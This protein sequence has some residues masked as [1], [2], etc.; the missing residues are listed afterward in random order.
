MR[1][2]WIADLGA[3]A[4]E[5]AP[6]EARHL[7]DVLRARLGD[8]VRLFD[9]EGREREARVA[10]VDRRG[11]RLSAAGPVL[12]APPPGPPDVALVL[13][14]LRGEAMDRVVRGATELGVR[15]ILPLVAARSVRGAKDGRGAARWRRIAREAARQSGRAHLPIVR[16]PAPLD[17]LVGALPA[18]RRIVLWEAERALALAPSGSA[19][20]LAVG[21]EGGWEADE[22]ERLR[23]SGFETR[24]L[25]DATLRAETAALA[26]VAIVRTHSLKGGAGAA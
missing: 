18:G 9:G 20:V 13:A 25:S 12:R 23:A 5:L 2:L 21:P 22:I 24:G 19:C 6:E 26:S 11:V 8:A 16:D 14:L 3:D 4:L 7:R 10:A 15:E 1:R 17:S